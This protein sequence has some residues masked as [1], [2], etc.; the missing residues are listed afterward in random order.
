MSIRARNIL[1]SAVSGV[2][3][4]LGCGRRGLNQVPE[5]I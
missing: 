1:Y 4:G 5:A 3:H 2:S